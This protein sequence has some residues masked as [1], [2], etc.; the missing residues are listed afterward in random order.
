[1][2]AGRPTANAVTT[3]VAS[4]A[5]I[6]LNVVLIPSGGLVGSAVATLLA[7]M[8]QWAMLDATARRSMP[9][10]GAAWGLRLRLAGVG[11]GVTAAAFLPDGP[12][13]LALRLIGLAVAGGLFLNLLRRISGWGSGLLYVGQHRGRPAGYRR[14]HAGRPR[15]PG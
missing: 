9:L 12:G 15:P 11:A 13:V 2:A 14:R 5:H 6:V 1:M 8:L 10:P 7:Y 3:M 4:A